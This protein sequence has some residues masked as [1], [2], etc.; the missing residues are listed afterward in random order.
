M[1]NR[2]FGAETDGRPDKNILMAHRNTCFLKI[3]GFIHA[4]GVNTGADFGEMKGQP[5]G[6]LV[7][8]TVSCLACC[9][10][11]HRRNCKGNQCASGKKHRPERGLQSAASSK[12]AERPEHFTAKLDRRFSLSGGRAGVRASSF[13]TAFFRRGRGPG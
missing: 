11:A 13:P 8:P 6:L 1:V 10:V 2:A 7:T 5:L 3:V 12:F 4:L 9:V